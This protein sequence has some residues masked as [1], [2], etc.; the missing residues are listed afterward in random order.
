MND[1]SPQTIEPPITNVHQCMNAAA[2]ES[3]SAS[4]AKSVNFSVRLPEELKN[5]AQF[6]CERNCTD[7]GTYLRECT[8]ALLRDYG[9]TPSE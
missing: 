2:F 9:A 3:S 5:Q 1:E 6:I 8:K 7:L 4:K